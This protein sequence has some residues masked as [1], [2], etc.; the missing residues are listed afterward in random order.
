M[1]TSPKPTWS[2]LA[3]EYG[4]ARTT[5]AAQRRKTG[6]PNTPDKSEWDIFLKTQTPNKILELREE[7]LRLDAEIKRAKLATVQRETVNLSDMEEWVSVLASKIEQ[8]L[9]QA[10]D[11]DVPSRIA[12]LNVTEAREESRKIHDDVRERVDRMWD[13]Q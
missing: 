11:V 4:V 12:G 1:S 2:N 6:S 10:F 8:I 7:N 13:I 3:A 5:I 9:R